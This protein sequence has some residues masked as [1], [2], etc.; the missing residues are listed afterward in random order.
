MVQD[1]LTR[2]SLSTAVQINIVL[3]LT[4]IICISVD[5]DPRVEMSCTI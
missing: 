1:V 4:I 2:G 3:Q 5:K